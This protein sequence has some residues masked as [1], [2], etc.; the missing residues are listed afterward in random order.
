MSI[1]IELPPDIEKTL[2]QR[3]ADTRQTPEQFAAFIIEMT[4]KASIPPKELTAEEWIAEWKAWG[5]SHRP[6]PHPADDSRDS[7]YEGRGE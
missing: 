1:T 4:M 6:L 7:I 5:A 3:A 2:R